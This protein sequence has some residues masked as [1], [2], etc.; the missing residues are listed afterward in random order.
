MLPTANTVIRNAGKSR[1][2][3]FEVEGSLRADHGG[4]AFRGQLRVRTPSTAAIRTR[5]PAWTT[6]ATAC[7]GPEYTYNLALQYDL[8]L[9]ESLTSLQGGLAHGSPAPNCRASAS[10]AE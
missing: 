9:L 2:M 10:S 7:L 8:P 3:G 5:F 1:S 4:P 6:R